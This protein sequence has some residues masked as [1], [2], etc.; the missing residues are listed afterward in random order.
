MDPLNIELA[1]LL[2]NRIQKKTERCI[3]LRSVQ[4]VVLPAFNKIHLLKQR[5][6]LGERTELLKSASEQHK[7]YIVRL[8]E[9]RCEYRNLVRMSYCEYRRPLKTGAFGPG[10]H[11]ANTQRHHV[12][13]FYGHYDN[14]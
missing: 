4:E 9:L 2:K 6:E 10:E 3:T 8:G 1:G 5:K 12:D 11:Y 14:E 13:L 7:K